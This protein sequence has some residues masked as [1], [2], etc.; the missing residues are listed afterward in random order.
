MVSKLFFCS[1]FPDIP[2]KVARKTRKLGRTQAIAKRYSFH[3]NAKKTSR[4]KIILL[5]LLNTQNFGEI[6]K[7]NYILWEKS[8]GHWSVPIL[9]FL[10]IYIGGGA[11]SHYAKFENIFKPSKFT[12]K[13][14]LML[15]FWTDQTKK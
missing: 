6:Y 12:S 13:W 5:Y 3:T 14:F 7:L 1:E 8:L 2:D 10:W 11:I 4:K 9:S 15:V